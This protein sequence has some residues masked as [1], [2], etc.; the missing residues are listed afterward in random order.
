[1]CRDEASA[2]TR[3]CSAREGPRSSH[4]YVKPE[5]EEEKEGKAEWTSEG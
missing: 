3:T 4:R 1:M 5:D 2:F